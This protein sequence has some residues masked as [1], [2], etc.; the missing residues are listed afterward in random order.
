MDMWKKVAIQAGFMAL[1]YGMKK[2]KQSKKKAKKKTAK[3]GR[4]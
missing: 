1:D 4:K 2:R 3:K